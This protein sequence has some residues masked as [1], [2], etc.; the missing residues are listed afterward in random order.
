MLPFCC[1]LLVVKFRYEIIVEDKNLPSNKRG[2]FLKKLS[3]FS[4][5][6][7]GGFVVKKTKMV[8][9]YYFD[10]MSCPT[11]YCHITEKSN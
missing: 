6:N 8:S 5:K 4:I 10:F 1:L 7:E 11:R 3:R 2:S 9:D